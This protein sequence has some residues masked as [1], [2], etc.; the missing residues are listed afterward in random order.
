MIKPNENDLNKYFGKTFKNNAGFDFVVTGIESIDKKSNKRYIVQFLE[1]GETTTALGFNILKGEVK[2]KNNIKSCEEERIVL[3]IGDLHAPFTKDGYLDFCK[4]MHYKYNCTD[5]VFLGDIIDNH[6]SSFHDT[7]PDGHG[8]GEELERAIDQISKWY[9]EFPIAYVCEGNHDT[10]NTRKAFSSGLSK[11]WIKSIPEVLSTPN[12]EYSTQ[13]I[14][15]DFLF[16]HGTGRVARAR[17]AEDSISVC[18]GHY[19]SSSYVE[20]YVGTNGV[21]KLAVQVGCGIDRDSYAFAY[22][23]HFKSPHVNVAIINLNRKTAV[24]EYM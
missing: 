23:K 21:R 22:G 17:C 20:N 16:T 19:H 18:Q 3:A 8:A 12:W 15:G 2:K 6:F 5:V 1:D 7:D 4:E 13:H 11:R 14:L 24:L 9:K 10:L